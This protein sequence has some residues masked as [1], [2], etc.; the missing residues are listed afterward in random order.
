ME[1]TSATNPTTEPVRN[2][3]AEHRTLLNSSAL[4]PSN[5]AMRRE[6]FLWRTCTRRVADMV[7]YESEKA[8]CTHYGLKASELITS[9]Q[10]PSWLFSNNTSE[11]VP[12]PNPITV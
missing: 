11:I 4:N 12:D 10:G 8:L 3:K 9:L 1:Y 6:K 5:S 2:P 7:Q